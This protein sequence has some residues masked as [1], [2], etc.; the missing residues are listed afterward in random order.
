M[1][2]FRKSFLLLLMMLAASASAIALRP[3]SKLADERP[4]LDLKSMIPA[5]F[6]D[7]H[8]EAQNAAYM[9]NPQQKEFLDTIYSETLFRSYVNSRGYRI[10][11]SIAYGGDQSRATQVH[12]PEVCYPAQ[13]FTLISRHDES[14]VIPNGSIP[15]TRLVTKLG[16]RVEPVTYWI[17][18]GD[19]VVQGGI[20]KKLT[21][22]AFR[23]RGKVPDGLLFRVSSVDPD[24]KAA[25]TQQAKF[26]DEVLQSVKDG[27]RERLGAAPRTK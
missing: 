3:S 25:F 1:N 13:G 11:L 5:Q 14:I 21:E 8:Q 15:A 6:G 7:W 16:Q 9:V 24:E 23:L 18:V 2:L 22:I 26:I 27:D 4:A 20:N 19:S 10:M 17:T 12:K